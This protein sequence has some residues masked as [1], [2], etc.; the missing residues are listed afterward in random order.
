MAS[1]A[2]RTA[3]FRSPAAIRRTATTSHA[4]WACWW[5]SRPARSIRAAARRRSR[6]SARPPSQ[7]PPCRTASR[8]AVPLPRN[9]SSTSPGC[10]RARQARQGRAW[11]RTAG[12]PSRRT[13]SGRHGAP[14]ARH[15]RAGQVAGNVRVTRRGG[16]VAKPNGFA[17]ERRVTRGRSRRR[18]FRRAAGCC[19]SRGAAC[20]GSCDVEPPGRRRAGAGPARP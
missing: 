11:P 9:G 3:R 18:A 16:K 20:G 19:R 12:A 6:R 14:Q 7:S 2:S 17:V 15:T 8:A 4:A 5:P 13:G 10:H 1:A